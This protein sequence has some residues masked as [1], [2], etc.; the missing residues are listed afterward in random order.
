MTKSK[1]ADFVSARHPEAEAQANFLTQG[2][3]YGMT[4]WRPQ[5]IDIWI[6]YDIDFNRVRFVF[7]AIGKGWR[8]SHP[9]RVERDKMLDGDDWVSES[10]PKLVKAF[11]RREG[12]YVPRIPDN[13]ILGEE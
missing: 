6:D 13:I 7:E 9:L 8:Y 2:V 11:R 3:I 10:Y 12:W 4:P 1:I 5:K